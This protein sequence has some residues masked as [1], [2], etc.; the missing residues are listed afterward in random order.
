MGSRFDQRRP[1]AENSTEICEAFVSPLSLS[2]GNKNMETVHGSARRPGGCFC[3]VCSLP[4]LPAAQPPSR[5]KL[6]SLPRSVFTP[7]LQRRPCNME[8]RLQ[9]HSLQGGVERLQHCPCR[10]GLRLQR[11]PFSVGLSLQRRPRHRDPQS[12]RGCSAVLV[13]QL[14]RQNSEAIKRITHSARTAAL[15]DQQPS[16]Q[17]DVM[18][19]EPRGR[20]CR[21]DVQML[22]HTRTALLGVG[23]AKRRFP[24][25]VVLFSRRLLRLGSHWVVT[26]CV[27]CFSQE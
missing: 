7:R 6:A 20:R 14:G 25:N 11:H 12:L 19:T 13:G 27:V 18:D 1:G 3:A 4:R 24:H 17:R 9:R 26:N 22:V 2:L 8:Q 21:D 15:R 10:V 23:L 5:G 16:C